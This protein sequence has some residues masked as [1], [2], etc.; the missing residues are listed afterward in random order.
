MSAIVLVPIV[1]RLYDY[2]GIGL[3]SRRLAAA[4][5]VR[6]VYDHCL[7]S[8]N[9]VMVHV[10]APSTLVRKILLWWHRSVGMCVENSL[11]TEPRLARSS[12]G[13]SRRGGSVGDSSNPSTCLQHSTP[14]LRHPPS[15]RPHHSP[16]HQSLLLSIRNHPESKPAHAPP[17]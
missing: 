13:D 16:Q 10:T 7:L 5:H 6:D 11:S 17:A 1:P 14:H 12:M 2:L 15:H 4:S 8:V 3:M 9:D